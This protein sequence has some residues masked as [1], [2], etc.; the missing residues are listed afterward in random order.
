MKTA[1]TACIQGIYLRNVKYAESFHQ[2]HLKTVRLDFC[3]GCRAK[4]HLRRRRMGLRPLENRR[5]SSVE[6]IRPSKKTKASD[7]SSTHRDKG[8]SNSVRYLKKKVSLTRSST[9]SL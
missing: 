8:N 7:M 5:G 3:C 6:L 1:F 9:V 2:R 4:N